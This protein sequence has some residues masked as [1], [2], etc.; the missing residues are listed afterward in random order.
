MVNRFLG[1]SIMLNRTKTKSIYEVSAC[2]LVFIIWEVA[3][4]VMQ[5]VTTNSNKVFPT[6]G[7]IFTEG[8]RGLSRYSPIVDSNLGDIL[9]G[10]SSLLYHGSITFVRVA[11]A[12]GISTILAVVSALHLSKYPI[13]SRIV[14]APINLARVLPS[15]A[16]APLFIL[17]FGATTWASLWFIVFSVYFIVLIS[18][19]D[20]I[21]AVDPNVIEYSRTLGISSRSILY[22]VSFPASLINMRGSVTF[23]GLVAWTSVLSAELNGLQ[24]GLGYIIS[25][26]IRFSNIAD[27]FLSAMC[28]CF[29]SF[30]SMKIIGWAM[31]RITIWRQ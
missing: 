7:Y 20:A 10:M 21:Q 17:W 25:D 29:L 13:L 24:D 14:S 6:L 28:F 22:H 26:N 12:F 1:E 16:M 23:A 27:M 11:V 15:F 4:L 31:D 2:A 9:L 3:A 18:E 8:V 19:L 30:F 5:H